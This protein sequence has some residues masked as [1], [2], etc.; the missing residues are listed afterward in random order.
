MISPPPVDVPVFETIEVSLECGA[1]IM[2]FLDDEVT[3]SFHAG[4]KEGVYDV[5]E[6]DLERAKEIAQQRIAQLWE[7]ALS[8]CRDTGHYP[9]IRQDSIAH[10][11]P[12]IK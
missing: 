6:F 2:G 11:A 12:L 3:C 10:T 7:I 5:C 1:L 9:S 8:H 4:W